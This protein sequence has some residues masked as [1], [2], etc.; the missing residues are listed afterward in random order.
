MNN[1]FE[2]MW[3]KAVGPKFKIL[4]GTCL[5]KLRK[6]KGRK[7]SVRIVGVSAEIGARYLTEPTFLASMLLLRKSPIHKA[8]FFLVTWSGRVKLTALCGQS[9]AVP[10]HSMI[11][12][13]EVKL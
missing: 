12:Y 9:K 7:F 3:K 10:V 13:R 8:D 5:G 1:E 2:R 11:A 6:K 4:S